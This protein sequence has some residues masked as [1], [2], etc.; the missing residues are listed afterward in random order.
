MTTRSTFGR[1]RILLTLALLLICTGN[2]IGQI[3]GGL[4]E[5]TRTD[6]GGNSYITGTVFSPSGT[7]IN[8]R[9]RIRLASMTAGEVITTSDDTGKF[10]FS[11]LSIG[12][13]TIAIDGEQDFESVSQQVDILQNRDIQNISFRLTP[14]RKPISKPKAINVENAAVPKKVLDMYDAALALSMVGDHKAAVEQLKLAVAEFPAFMLAYTEM[15]VQYLRL[16][17]LE[18]ADEALQVALKIRP[19]AYE[20]LVNRGIVMFRLKRFTEAETLLRSA[21]KAKEQSAVAHFYL[22]RTFASR[23]QYDTAEREFN[24]AIKIGGDQ[25]KEAHRMLASMFL[26]RE[27][28]K[29]ALAEL[30][31]Y[32]KLAPQAADAEQLRGV[33][34][35]LKALISRKP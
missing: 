24:T 2:I 31:I 19:D 13:Y 25:M 26:D 35:E 7:P 20:P 18:K 12:T 23:K 22:G 15:G 28:H 29:R 30:E 34:S 27:D 11:K 3:A 21:L 17:E 6:F 4:T 33:V 10:V 32:L 16:N 8:Y 1:I 5:T 14:K 9:I